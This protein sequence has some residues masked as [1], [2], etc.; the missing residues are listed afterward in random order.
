MGLII[1]IIIMVI[2]IIIMIIIILG[3]LQSVLQLRGAF[4]HAIEHLEANIIMIVIMIMM[5]ITITITITMITIIMIITITGVL[6]SVRELSGALGHTIEHLEPIRQGQQPHHRGT[7]QLAPSLVLHV[8]RA[9][10]ALDQHLKVLEL[11]R[12]T[13]HHV[14][15]THTTDDVPALF[16]ESGYSN[17]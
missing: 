2:N 5:M 12:I 1:V 13:N 10:R 4:G 9:V 3:V 15:R 17:D 6:Q 7:V 8:A 14:Q 16:T 11:C